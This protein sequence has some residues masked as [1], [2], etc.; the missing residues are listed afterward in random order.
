VA[1][2][3]AAELAQRREAP[4]KNGARSERRMRPKVASVKLTFR[5]LSGVRVRELGAVG[6][7]RFDEWAALKAKRQALDRAFERG[8]EW[9]PDFYIALAN[10]ERLAFDRFE[11]HVLAVLESRGD[12]SLAAYIARNYSKGGNGA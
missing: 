11:P 10:A 4:V 7:Q 5:R 3:S 9:S 8:D 2:L 12:D 6:K 1:S